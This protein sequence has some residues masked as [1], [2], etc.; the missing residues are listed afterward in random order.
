MLCGEDEAFL[1]S[2]KQP[3]RKALRLNPLKSNSPASFYFQ[4][5]CR[6]SVPWESMGYYTD[7]TL[8][9]G[10]HPY[11]EAGV[12]YIQEPSAMAP[13][14]YMDVREEERILDLC[15]APGGKSTQIAGRM[16]GTGLLVCNEIHPTRAK[17][18]SENIERMGIAN[19]L[20]TNETPQRL[21]QRFPNF[22]DK[23]LV[24]APCSGEGMFRKNPEAIEEWSPEAVLLCA[25]RQ[26][27][28]LDCA[29]Q[30][31]R[32]G[33]RMVYSTCTFAPEEDEGAILRFLIRH[34]EYHVLEMPLSEGMTHGKW[35]YLQD[36]FDAET[37]KAAETVENDRADAA[38]RAQI[39]R[40]I[41]LWPHKLE[42]E[43]HFVAVLIKGERETQTN[44]ADRTVRA[45]KAA[46]PMT[47]RDLDSFLEFRKQHLVKPLFTDRTRFLRFG[48]H[49]YVLPEGAP[50]IDG[51]KVL[52]PGLELGIFKKDRFEPAH[53]LAH[54]LKM[55]DAV[56][57]LDLPADSAEVKEYLNGQSLR[58]DA[59]AKAPWVLTCVD[60]FPLGWSKYAG[61]ILK[62]HYPKGLRKNTT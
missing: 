48:D 32:P 11:H 31:L 9:A 35:E 17:I 22:F 38:L 30:M 19:A 56:N 3:A 20:V 7:E 29:N 46:K 53:A 14:S 50:A 21:S 52:R 40:T 60:G 28:I 36:A 15:A 45:T 54:A 25:R 51:L 47:D 58:I 57:T 13:V 59:E 44:P 10:R 27:E 26:D 34:P 37:L 16:K 12:Y 1:L 43:G 2:E 23:I 39:E 42:G 41:R 24:D 8:A 6:T 5:N 49:L 55:T 33:G 62:N 61:G 4:E 18:L